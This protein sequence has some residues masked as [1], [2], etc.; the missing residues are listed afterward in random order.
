MGKKAVFVGPTHTCTHT[1]MCTCLHIH[2]C[3]AHLNKCVHIYIC[4]CAHTYMC[5]H[6][7]THIHLPTHQMWKDKSKCSQWFSLGNVII[8]DCFCVFFM[9]FYSFNDIHDFTF[10]YMLFLF[11]K[12]C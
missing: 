8:G 10:F 2:V 3:A 12:K 7:Y 1:H 6:M 4:I 9:Y 11:S 5:T